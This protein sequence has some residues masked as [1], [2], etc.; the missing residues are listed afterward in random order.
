[1][2]GFRGRRVGPAV[3]LSKRCPAAITM[4]RPTSRFSRSGRHREPR[5]LS[6]TLGGRTDAGRCTP[7]S[8]MIQDYDLYADEA[9]FHVPWHSPSA[10]SSALR[11][12]PPGFAQPCHR[13]GRPLVFRPR[14]S[15]ARRRHT[16][17]R[18]TGRSWMPSSTTLGRNSRCAPSPRGRTGSNGLVMRKSGSSS[19]TTRSCSE[20]W[21]PSRVIACTWI[22]GLFVRITAGAGC[23]S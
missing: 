12:G 1:M 18:S 19:P 11:S 3:L 4:G 22:K 6:A 14:S 21:A 17:C 15:G 13:S 16:R 10:R 20:T 7:M 23:T 8:P 5:P 2:P 9:F